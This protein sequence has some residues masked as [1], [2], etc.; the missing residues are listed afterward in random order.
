MEDSIMVLGHPVSTQI[1]GYLAGFF[2]TVSLLPQTIHT[3]KTKDTSGLSLWMYILYN[4]GVG[5]W[6]T[7]GFVL[8]SPPM[9]IFNGISLILSLTILWLKIKNDVLT[10][11][12]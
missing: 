9:I 8:D 11:K 5:F 7:Y 6:F 10:K 3:I 2:T 4:L 1:F 12:Q